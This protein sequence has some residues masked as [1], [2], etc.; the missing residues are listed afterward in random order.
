MQAPDENLQ[1]IH[2]LLFEI[3]SDI[4]K[5]NSTLI[6]DKN[7]PENISRNVA[8]LADKIDALN[9]LIRIL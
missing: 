5:L 1:E 8:M 3:S 9:D 4:D 2:T 7:I 6:S